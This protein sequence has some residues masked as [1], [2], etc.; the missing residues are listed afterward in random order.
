MER[1][2]KMS[3]SL[4]NTVNPDDICEE[5]GADTLRLYEMFLGPIEMAKPWNTDSISGVGTFIRRTWALFVGDNDEWL[6]KEDAATE[7]ELKL[8]HKTI[9]KVEEGIERLAFNTC[10][11]PFMVFVKE[12]AKMKGNKREVLEP[13]LKILS[14]FAPHLCEEL[15]SRMG[16]TE[17][18]LWA[19]FPQWE[20][21]YVV[22][23]TIQYPVQINGKVRT[24]IAAAADADKA[25]V[26]EIA[27]SNEKVKEWMGDK[28]PRKVIVVPG[29]IVNIVV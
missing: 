10:V 1:V 22:E 29:R 28:T 9:K 5:Y 24:K 16:H 17:S 7:E 26:E 15:W 19:E 18:I 3:K 27:L 8:L 13:F 2:E 4:Y 11:P 21:K 6:V 23:N 14:P 20:E 12:I 25:A